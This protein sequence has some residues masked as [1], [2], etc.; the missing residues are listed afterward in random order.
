MSFYD[1]NT[2]KCKKWVYERRERL[3]QAVYKF[4]IGSK[5]KICKEVCD[6]KQVKKFDFHHKDPRNKEF[7]IGDAVSRGYSLKRI[8]KEMKKCQFVCS[9]CHSSITL[10]SLTG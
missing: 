8:R 6:K 7:E 9:E 4:K 3:K 5:C 10:G 1:R 2:D